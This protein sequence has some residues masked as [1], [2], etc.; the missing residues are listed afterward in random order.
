MIFIVIIPIVFFIEKLV[1]AHAATREVLNCLV[2][3]Q[4]SVIKLQ[5][6]HA[7]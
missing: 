6:F 5:L 3:D 7:E 2:A 4:Q 1:A